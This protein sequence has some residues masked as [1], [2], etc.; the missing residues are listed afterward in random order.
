MFYGIKKSFVQ[1][2]EDVMKSIPFRHIDKT[3]KGSIKPF[4]NY[5]TEKLN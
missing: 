4:L 5:L 2:V 1:I 3:Y